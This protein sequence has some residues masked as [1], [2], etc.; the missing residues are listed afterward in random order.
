MRL[1]LILAC[2]NIAIIGLFFM[3]GWIAVPDFP[4]N[5]TTVPDRTAG[6]IIV[7]K[8]ERKM[9]LVDK[10]SIPIKTYQIS[11]GAQPIG[12]KTQ[13][14]DE[15]TPE[16]VYK[17]ISRN[18]K[19]RFHKS[20]RISYPNDADTVQAKERGASP[21]G[22]IMVHGL[23][24]GLGWI[25]SLHRIYDTW[26]D[27]CIAVTDPEIEEIWNAVPDGTPIEIRP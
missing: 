16:G 27:G 10:N 11:L 21:G 13:E 9:D 14:G 12:H 17:I 5:E 4:N 7:H 6:R 20:L 24:N 23:P 18:E 19:S 3:L 8:A 25:G 15:K 2:K 1:R 26:T 22:D